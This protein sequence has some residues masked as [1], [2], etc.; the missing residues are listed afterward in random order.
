[1][2]VLVFRIKGPY[3]H[4]RRVYT[5]T[6][7][8]SYSFPTRTAILGIIGAII[9]I[10][11]KARAEH[12][13]YLKDLD[14]TTSLEKPVNKMR[15]PLNYQSIKE[16]GRIQIPLEVIKNPSYLIFVKEFEYYEKLKN[17]LENK[18]TVFTP[19]L[20]I[21]EFIASFEYVGEYE[22]KEAPLPCE[23]SSVIPSSKV[24]IE[25][26]SG[27]LYVKERA[28]RSMDEKRNYLEHETYILRKD[29]KPIRVTEGK[30]FSVGRWNIIWM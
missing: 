26:E 7:A 6:S 27:V 16:S 15:I 18:E 11:R 28:T 3:A 23:V 10:E 2:N 8:S 25:P 4:F 5:T 19:Y 14:V 21:S 9:G 12:L 22:L 30:V 20:G 29:A 24:K 17:F 1:M 13:K